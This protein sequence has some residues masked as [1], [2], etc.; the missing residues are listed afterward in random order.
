[1]PWAARVRDCVADIETSKPDHI[2]L[3]DRGLKPR[4]DPQT[5]RRTSAMGPPRS[6]S[7]AARRTGGHHR[8]GLRR[9][10][11]P[12]YTVVGFDLQ[13]ATAIASAAD[14]LRR[15][16]DAHRAAVPSAR[17]RRH[18]RVRQAVGGDRRGNGG[19]RGCSRPA[20]AAATSRTTAFRRRT[21]RWWSGRRDEQRRRRARPAQLALQRRCPDRR[22]GAGA[23]GRHR[24]VHTE[25]L[26]LPAGRWRHAAS[27]VHPL[28]QRDLERVGRRRGRRRRDPGP[29]ASAARRALHT[30]GDPSAAGAHRATPARP[31]E[32]L[33]G[34]DPAGRCRSRSRSSERTGD[35]C[36]ARGRGGGA[37]GVRWTSGVDGPGGSGAGVDRVLLDGAV[38]AG[39]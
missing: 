15:G 6:R 31:R 35:Q 34:S 16:R 9:R 3:A 1:M 13:P 2:E 36:A 26:R 33:G 14:Q 21:P 28:L 32:R 11:A 10:T 24:N 7:S 23:R 29:G 25:L 39:F 18:G 38:A 19:H 37:A 27:G 20:T 22:A 4:H 30:R 8:A 12:H 5:P 17:A